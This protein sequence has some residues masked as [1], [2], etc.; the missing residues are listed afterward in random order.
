MACGV[1]SRACNRFDIAFDVLLHSETQ[2]PCIGDAAFI[3]WIGD[4][5]VLYRQ[6][7]DAAYASGVG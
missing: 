7:E 2:Y 1:Y 5:G 6:D 3:V 4:S